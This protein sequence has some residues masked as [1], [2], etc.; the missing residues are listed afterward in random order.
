[1]QHDPLAVR[2]TK[3]HKIQ[4]C[5]TLI[6]MNKSKIILLTLCFALTLLIAA[7]GSD[8]EAP[9]PEPTVAPTATA[10]PTNSPAPTNTPVPAT[11]APA[12]QVESPL[13]SVSPLETPAAEAAADTSWE[14]AQ[15]LSGFDTISAIAADTKSGEPEKGMASI[16]GLLYHY[17]RDQVIPGTQF[18]LTPAIIDGDKVYPPTM[19]VGPQPEKGDVLGFTNNE[20]QLFLTNV[21]PG[22]YYIAVWAVYDWF[23]VQETEE[24]GKPLLLT[25]E[26][27]DKVNLG[28]LYTQ[29]L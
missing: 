25:L 17:A 2:N 28:L 14:N 13:Q 23:V 27:G 5:S 19:Y 16:S 4:S 29:W 11:V 26:A 10:V 1:M 20:G 15:I 9:T 6:P 22:K 7:C 18:Y 3:H 21:P 8:D 12:S 24:S